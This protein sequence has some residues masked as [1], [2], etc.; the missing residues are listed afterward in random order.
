MARRDHRF[1]PFSAV[2]TVIP[3]GSANQEEYPDPRA[4]LRTAVA[5]YNRIVNHEDEDPTIKMLDDAIQSATAEATDLLRARPGQGPLILRVTSEAEI[6]AIA[7]FR[8]PDNGGP[9]LL[10]TYRHERNFA[11]LMGA[12]QFYGFEIRRE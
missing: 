9:I 4:S 12:A 2:T 3:S 6:Q 10:T 8:D 1:L 7:R 5:E 11:T